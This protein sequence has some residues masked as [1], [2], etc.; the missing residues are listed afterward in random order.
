MGSFRSSNSN[1]TG[2]GYLMI[3]TQW[4]ISG[5]KCIEVKP[6]FDRRFE[7]KFNSTAIGLAELSKIFDSNLSRI[8]PT[9]VVDSIYYD[10]PNFSLF[11]EGEEGINP[12]LKYR[13]RWYEKNSS[14]LS[15]EI[16][17]SE[18]LSRLKSSFHLPKTMRV[19]TSLITR[20]GRLTP[21][22]KVSYRRQYF[23]C[24]IGRITVDDH[25]WTGPLKGPPSF[26]PQT[27]IELKLPYSAGSEGSELS[28]LFTTNR[29]S[30]YSLAMGSGLR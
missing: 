2:I 25:V 30:K 24:E 14:L 4:K 19:P 1:A 12:R 29:I 8:F 27:I 28:R 15:L 10:T 7:L 13:V 17:R 23:Q 11:H 26:H 21:T 3:E 9:R 16:K 18:S 5:S 6:E 20:R 22:G